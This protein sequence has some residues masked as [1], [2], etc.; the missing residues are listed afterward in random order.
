MTKEELEKEVEE[1]WNNTFKVFCPT[2][3]QLDRIC[4]DLLEPR[5]KRI[6]ELE[7]QLT[8]RNCLDCSNHSSKLRMRTLE[9]EKENAELKATNKSLLESCEGATMMYQDLQKANNNLTE[10]KKYIGFLLGVV[11]IKNTYNKEI[12]EEIAK[13]EAFLNSEVEK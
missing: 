4:T 1:W 11:H 6:A 8:H 12:E 2:H 13:A 3:E 5:E 10:A 9:L 7:H